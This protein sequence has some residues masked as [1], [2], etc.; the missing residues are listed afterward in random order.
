MKIDIEEVYK[1]IKGS[2]YLE[3]DSRH[4]ECF[5]SGVKTAHIFLKTQLA[6]YETRNKEDKK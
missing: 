4:T 3:N 1:M 5:R 6:D 2:E